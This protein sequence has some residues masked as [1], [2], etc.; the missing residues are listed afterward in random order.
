MVFSKNEGIT[1]SIEEIPSIEG[2]T[3][4]PDKHA[5]HIG[6]KMSTATS[7][8]LMKSDESKA[9]YGESPADL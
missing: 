6:Y 1:F 3:G 8:K 9:Y 4:I 5:V 2:F 7:N